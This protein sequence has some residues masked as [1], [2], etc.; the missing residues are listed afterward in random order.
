MIT[1]IRR[2]CCCL[3][4]DGSIWRYVRGLR[5]RRAPVLVFRVEGAPLKSDAERAGAL[6]DC[7]EACFHSHSIVPGSEGR[8]GFPSSPARNKRDASNGKSDSDTEASEKDTKKE[9]GRDKK[10][11]SASSSSG[12]GSSSRSSSGSSSRSSSGSSS[13][14]S[15]SSGSS[16]HSSSSSSSSGSSTSSSTTRARPKRK[17]GSPSHSKSPDVKKVKE[18]EEKKKKPEKPK[19]KVRS[20]SP[21]PRRKRK[22]RSPTP[23]PIKIHVGRLTR[24][25]TR[26]HI[27]EIFSTYGAVKSVEFPSERCHPHNGRGFAYIEFET[28]N[29]AENAM[30][31]MDGGQID[32]Q[33]I[34]AAPV[35]L[36]KPRPPPPRR[37]PP[38][39]RRAP[40]RRAWSPPR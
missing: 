39:I 6:A 18:K 4:G 19:P 15:S 26:E 29:E 27:L 22:E 12:S 24:N 16:S 10:K 8:S 1:S 32:G 5:R 37:S 36:P 23:R 34:T 17:P 30:K 28:P 2:S 13:S 9:R 3:V 38:P 40:P 35:L 25:V 31:H 33:E 7:F 21:S 11:K 14:H 20:R